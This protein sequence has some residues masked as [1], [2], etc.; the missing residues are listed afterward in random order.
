MT[1]DAAI[2]LLFLHALP[3]DGRMWTGQVAAFPTPSYAPTLYRHGGTMRDWA[4]AALDLVR[5]ER[6]IVVGCSVGGS[7]AL[8][9]ARLAPERVAALV[10]VG[11][12]ARHLP[13]DYEGRNGV[14][15]VHDH[16]LRH[17][18]ALY[19]RVGLPGP[20]ES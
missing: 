6:I 5:E 16:W 17:R 10:L 12:N 2:G 11:T 14:E 7:V 20:P 19:E 9:V 1:D 4:V 15:Y 18:S 3:L 13:W 8:E